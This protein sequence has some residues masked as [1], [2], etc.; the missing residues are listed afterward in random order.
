MIIHMFGISK[1]YYRLLNDNSYM[2][3]SAKRNGIHVSPCGPLC[4]ADMGTPCGARKNLSLKTKWGLC[5]PKFYD[6][7][8][9]G[10]LFIFHMRTYNKSTTIS[11]Q[12][13][14]IKC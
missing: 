5:G 9:V 12:L 4:G 11:K 6:E 10:H 8:Y 3:Q 1:G 14:F 13:I 7:S 2:S